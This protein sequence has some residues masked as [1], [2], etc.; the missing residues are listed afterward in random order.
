MAHEAKE[1][2]LCFKFDTIYWNVCDFT[3]KRKNVGQYGVFLDRA[4]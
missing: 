4:K 3:R 1:C 2:L